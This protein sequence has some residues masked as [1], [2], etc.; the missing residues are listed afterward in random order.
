MFAQQAEVVVFEAAGQP[1]PLVAPAVVAADDDA[2]P[3][4]PARGF[5]LGLLLGTA[6]LLVLGYAI[7]LAT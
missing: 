7:W 5:A 6:S 2:D 4:A 1:A 3:L